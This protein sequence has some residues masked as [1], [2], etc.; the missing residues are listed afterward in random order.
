MRHMDNT[1]VK[2]EVIIRTWHLSC[3]YDDLGEVV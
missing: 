2:F 1:K 3:T